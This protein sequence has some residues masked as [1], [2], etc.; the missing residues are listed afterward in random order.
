MWTTCGRDCEP[1]S[2]SSSTVDGWSVAGN[3]ESSDNETTI[4][5][6]YWFSGSNVIIPTSLPAANPVEPTLAATGVNGSRAG[7]I[8][9]GGTVVALLGAGVAMAARRRAATN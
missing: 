3:E 9:S 7:L 8:A 6:A 2:V 5:S 4:D 1:G